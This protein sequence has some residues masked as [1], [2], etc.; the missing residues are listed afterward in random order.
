MTTWVKLLDNF[1]EHP[2]VVEAGED[3]A[4]VYVCGLLYCSRQLSDGF[5]P[6]GAVRI[7]TGRRNALALISVL[8][9][10]GLWEKAPGGWQVHDYEE[11][12]R[13]R[14]EVEAIRGKAGR[15]ASIQR[16]PQLK[17][18]I[19]ERD[20]DHCRYCGAEVDW[21]NRRGRLGATYD[22]ILPAGP[23]TFDNLVVCCR[24][25]NS[26]KQHR[27]PE[28]A[29][30]PL[31]PIKSVLSSVQNA[32]QVPVLPEAEAV[33]DAEPSLVPPARID[34]ADLEHHPVPKLTAADVTVFR[35]G[36]NDLK[37]QH[38]HLVKGGGA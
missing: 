26:A 20:G 36:L 13:T 17:A 15:R 22:H 3:A 32:D 29:G 9:D 11:H 14:A 37:Q 23:D 1:T 30:M 12:Q 38:P 8:V 19:R 27:T 28:E 2:K 35:S 21:S 7:L 18:A 31:L 34:Q 10:V 24:G 25:C 5:I 6:T 4:W 16:N 33:A